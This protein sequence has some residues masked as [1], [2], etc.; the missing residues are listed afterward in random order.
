ME[1]ERSN[2]SEL[3]YSKEV[4]NKG[5]NETKTLGMDYDKQNTLSVGSNPV[6]IP[7]DSLLAEKFIFQAHKNTLHREVV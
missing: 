4:L 1:S 7:P 5:S 2:Q 3:T 6:F